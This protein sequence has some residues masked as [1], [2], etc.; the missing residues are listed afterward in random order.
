[1]DAETFITDQGNYDDACNGWL[2]FLYFPFDRIHFYLPFTHRLYLKHGKEL[3]NDG[4]EYCYS[5]A[6]EGVAHV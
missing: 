5:I 4:N 3:I 1:M 6:S 2:I